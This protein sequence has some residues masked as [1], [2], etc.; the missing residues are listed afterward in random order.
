MAEVVRRDSL[1]WPGIARRFFDPDWD[2]SPLR[3]E[4]YMD[5]DDM[6]VK[7]EMPGL[8]PDKDV[9]ISIYNGVLHIKAERRE[10]SE[11]H[12]KD[13]FRSEF[14]YG[15]FSRDIPLP[16]GATQNDV[17]AAYHDGVLTVRVPVPQRDPKPSKIPVTRS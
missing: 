5:G 16:N 8:D 9:N 11:H 1:E 2:T 12:D 13:G 6:V 14:R 10:E 3:V 17:K 7:T 15:S 4:E